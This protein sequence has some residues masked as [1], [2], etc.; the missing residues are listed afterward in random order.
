LSLTNTGFNDTYGY[1][2][3]VGVSTINGFTT[4]DFMQLSK[5]DFSNVARL[6]VNDMS[7][8]D[9][10]TVIKLDPNDQI[11]LTGVQKTSLAETQ[12]SLV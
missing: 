4:H 2:K 7:Q 5:A 11:A 12:F 8:V 6:F 1:Q 3:A 10:N 9:A